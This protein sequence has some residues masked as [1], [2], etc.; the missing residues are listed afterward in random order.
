MFVYYFKITQL[1]LFFFKMRNK[2]T[3]CSLYKVRSA[4]VAP[5]LRINGPQYVL[6]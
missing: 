1:R 4:S 5:Y 2:N 3:R 6:G